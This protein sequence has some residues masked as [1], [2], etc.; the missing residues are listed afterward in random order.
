MITAYGNVLG[1][2]TARAHPHDFIVVEELG[3]TPTGSG[4][5]H[6]LA[7]RKCGW[8]T[9]AVAG[10][11]AEHFALSRSAVS[12]AGRKDRH[13]ETTQWF[14]LHAPGDKQVIEPGPLAGGVEIVAVTRNNRKLRIGALRANRFVI[15]LRA[16]DALRSEVEKRLFEVARHGL[17][18]YFGEQRFG[19]DG[20]NF[21]RACAWLLGGNRVRSRSLRSTLLSAAR[22]ELFNRVLDYRVAA[23]SWNEVLPGERVML[24]DSHS[25]FSVAEPGGGI[26]RR[27]RRG[28]VHPSGPLPGRQKDGPDD[29]VAQLEA[30]V[31]ACQA[32]LIAALERQG[33]CAQRRALRVMPRYLGWLWHTPDSLEISF[34]LPAGSYATTLI[35]QVVTI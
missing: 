13:A 4:E 18:N 14:S 28:M 19:R 23:G 15:T 1:T 31:L 10:L 9:E 17:P 33:L 7:V 34:R 11:L 16:V 30:K 32:D 5:H 25:H 6:L 24:D 21:A 12:Y 20:D 8:T 27:V 22:S 3:F 29:Y 2:A 35:R 26:W